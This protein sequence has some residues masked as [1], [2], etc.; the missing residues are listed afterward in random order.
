MLKGHLNKLAATLLM[1]AILFAPMTADA[2]T[3][4]EVITLSQL[5]IPAAEIIKAIKKD[6]TVFKLKVQD[7]LELKQAGVAEEV[8]K[9]MLRSSEE[10]RRKTGARKDNAAPV[11]GSAMGTPAP[12]E[13]VKTPEEIAEERRRAREEAI[14]LL[15]ERKAA[16]RRQRE[17]YAQGVLKVGQDLANAGQFVQSIQ[18]FENF[19]KKGNYAPGS[20]EAYIA[21]FGIANALAKSNLLQSAAD[22]LKDLILQGTE[23][24]FY[25]EAF[26]DLRRLRKRINYSPP[27]LEELTEHYVGNFSAEFQDE[28]NYTLGEFFYD[29]NNY[30]QSMRFLEQVSENSEDTSKAFY[31]IG[32]IQVRNQL[33]SSALGSFQNAVVAQE[34]NESSREVADLA[35]LA[36]ARIAY[37]SDQFDAAIY[38][39]RKVAKESTKLPIAFYESAW[40]YF[41]KGDSS[42]ALGTFQALQ[43]PAFSHY[44]YPELWVLE[45]TVYLNLCHIEETREA[46]RMFDK[47]VAAYMEPL[48]IFLKSMR[49][50]AD[51]YT[52][53][54]E[55]VNRVKIHLP[56]RLTHPVLAD[57]EF[58]RLYKTIEQIEWEIQEM[59]RAEGALGDTARQITAKL[60]NLKQAKINEV[61]I[62]IQRSLKR[63]EDEMRKYSVSV[64]EIEIELDQLELDTIDTE[65]A[66]LA[67]QEATSDSTVSQ[68]AGALA[69][70]GAD[71]TEWPFEAEYWSD[72]IGSYRAFIKEKCSP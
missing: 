72:E 64:T 39:Y 28:F 54:V 40:T 29:M 4:E 21:Q 5:N 66:V 33:Y 23:M 13:R 24:Q 41:V 71:S 51:Y 17:T 69:I 35:Y 56:E 3:K 31:L 16:Q 18:Q 48:A 11:D 67:G 2:V 26:R 7:I 45:A 47:E 19:M 55:S 65:I 32:L 44:F 57:V 15:E 1:G 68:A 63:T 37:E 34:R 22:R 60:Q 27:E 10:F 30:A 58:Y 6:R 9:F 50:P 70:V 12:V 8:I 25:Q 38:Y 42:R 14:R 20:Q 43:S 53:F 49:R 36:L 62:K 61:G 59:N 52:A 46:L